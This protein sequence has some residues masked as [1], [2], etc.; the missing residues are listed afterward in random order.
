MDEML[1]D[2][3]QTC[4]TRIDAGASVDECFAA[5]PQQRDTLEAPLAAAA[6][7]RT[8]PRPALPAATQAALEARMLAIAAQRRAAATPAAPPSAQPF[9]PP[10]PTTLGPA[11]LLAGLLRTLGYRG[12]LARPWLRLASAVI[13]LVLALALGTG[14]LA[15][16]R[17]IV[18]AITGSR[19][20]PTNTLPAA[21]PFSL[22]GP[23][24]QI[25]PDG[26]VVNGI[27]VALAPQT[28]VEGT[29][30]VGAIAHVDGDVQADALLLARHITIE[31]PHLPATSAPIPL[32]PSSAPT[33]NP[34]PP[35]DGE[36]GDSDE[37]G[38]PDKPEK[39]KP[40]KPKP[41]K[42]DKPKPDK[43]KP[44]KG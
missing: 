36:P 14:A 28:T 29:P 8:L 7:I 34:M 24:E 18:R 35:P 43:P 11:A 13:A 33:T 5:Y 17:A 41:D 10:R 20:I 44:G 31:A 25:A 9:I 22:D 32:P 40:D 12:P 1:A 2:I 27:A 23:I 19:N 39:P 15:A 3:L 6:Q 37:T 42:P 30:V 38:K 4:L 26:W 16:A 21:T